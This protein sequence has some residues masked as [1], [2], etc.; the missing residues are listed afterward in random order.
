[1][2]AG[3]GVTALTA[4]GGKF[5]CGGVF[6]LAIAG[7]LLLIGLGCLAWRSRAI[8]DMTTQTLDV[9]TR[10]LLG[11]RSET[12]DLAAFDR[13]LLRHSV[14]LGKQRQRPQYAVVLA[15]ASMQRAVL[16]DNRMSAEEARLTAETLADLAGVPVEEMG[17][18]PVRLG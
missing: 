7:P 11:E 16:I 14:L 5:A 4:Q 8:V 12:H 6:L 9:R 13:V 15:D 2:A 10:G 17:T 1:M 18:R 3:G